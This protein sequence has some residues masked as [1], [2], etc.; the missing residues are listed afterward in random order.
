M[1]EP[2]AFQEARSEN[3]LPQATLSSSVVVCEDGQPHTP[4]ADTILE[5]APVALVYNGIS[6]AV[7][8]IT[9]EHMQDF[10]LGFSISEGI[11]KDASEIYELEVKPDGLGYSVEMQI[12]SQ[13][14]QALKE[15]RR[16]LTG[17]SG[18]GL[19]GTESLEQ[20]IR[21]TPKVSAPEL[22]DQ[23]IQQSLQQLQLHQPLQQL[24]GA[25]HGAA[26]CD[27]NGNIL[28]LREDV[29]RHNALDK[30][31]GALATQEPPNNGFALISSRL[32]YEMV[33]KCCYAGIGALVAVSAPTSL[34]INMAQEAG[35]LLIGFGRRGRH[36]IYNSA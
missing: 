29:G 24:T 18:C 4:R 3:A 28:T 32:S 25:S 23:A 35:L 27:L 1:R 11:V 22:S 5:E 31:I 8:M 33:Q 7:M 30:L 21:P 17:R 34:A 16:N 10:A 14:F 6:H 26:W 20:A 19:C 15:K 9:P 2:N 12:S 13:R 36:V